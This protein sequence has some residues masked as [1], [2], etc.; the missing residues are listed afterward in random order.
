[1]SAH[2]RPCYRSND[3][4]IGHGFPLKLS[5]GEKPYLAA[6]QRLLHSN[7]SLPNLSAIILR[8][9]LNAIDAYEV[10]LYIFLVTRPSL[11]R[12]IFQVS[13]TF[14]YFFY[15]KKI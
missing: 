10:A 5:E 8:C 1:M 13:Q 11:G 14:C 9:S 12:V 4:S 2:Q 15:H 6:L 7:G 3:S